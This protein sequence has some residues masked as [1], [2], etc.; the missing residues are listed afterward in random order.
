MLVIAILHFLKVRVL[1]VK[2]A[3]IKLNNFILVVLKLQALFIFLQVCDG[4]AN[5]N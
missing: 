4:E 5:M 1:N 3:V 2:S